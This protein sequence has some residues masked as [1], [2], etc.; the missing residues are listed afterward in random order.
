MKYSARIIKIKLSSGEV[1]CLATNLTKE[2][3]TT[4]E[5]KELYNLR[6]QIEINY[7]LLKESLKIGT[8]TSSKAELIK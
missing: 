8:I 2:E 7:H 4:D 6:W 5:M 3:V 1:E